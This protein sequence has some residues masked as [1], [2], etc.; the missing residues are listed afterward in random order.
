MKWKK[1][2]KKN[3]TKRKTITNKNHKQAK[4]KNNNRNLSEKELLPKVQTIF[5][6][7]WNEKFIP[8]YFVLIHKSHLLS[9]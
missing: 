1:A 8:Q 7:I 3:K 9:F 4:Q 2:N 6:N 5:K